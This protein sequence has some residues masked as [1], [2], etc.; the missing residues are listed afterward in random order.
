MRVVRTI[1]I[2]AAAMLLPSLLPAQRVGGDPVEVDSSAVDSVSYESGSLDDD[3]VVVRASRLRSIEVAG[4]R[5][6][7]VIGRELIE[8]S[9]RTD[10]ADALLLSPGVF[11]RRYG[12]SGS[13]ATLSLRG[14]AAGQTKIL[15]DGLPWRTSA[16]GGADLGTMPLENVEEIEVVRGGDGALYGSNALG[17]VVNIR[18]GA[19]ATPR[20]RSTIGLGSFGQRSLTLSAVHPL[21][22]VHSVHLHAAYRTATNDYPFAFHE[23]GETR[24]VRREN[25]QHESFTAGL[26]WRYD[27]DPVSA[28]I[29][30]DGFTTSRGVPGGVTQGNRELT[31]AELSEREGSAT[32]RVEG[33]IEGILLSTAVRLRLNHLRY[34]DPEAR[35]A[36]P[37]GVDNEYERSDL[38]GQVRGVWVP[39][40]RMAIEGVIDLDR[41]RLLGENLDPSVGGE[42]ERTRLGGMLH[43][44]RYLDSLPFVHRLTI[45]GGVRFDRFS[46]LGGYLSPSIGLVVQ[47]T[48]H[49][50]RLRGHVALNYRAPTFNEQYYLNVGNSEIGIERATSL[51]IGT[52]WAPTESL[53]LEGS[54]F[55]IDTRDRIVSIPRSPVSWTTLNVGRVESRGLE[56]GLR[57]SVLD[58]ALGGSLAYTRMAT[59]DR[60][61]GVT[62][63]HR[64]PYAPDEIATV[65]LVADLD[66]VRLTTS[67]E[68]ASHRYTLAWNSPETALPRYGVVDLGLGREIV[69]GDIDL[70]GSLSVRN[71]LN[72]RYQI[73]R[74]YPMPGRSLHLTLTL[75]TT[76]P[77]PE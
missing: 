7:T 45:D 61:G 67:L 55:R 12:G 76:R 77:T 71:L 63:G 37:E 31:E 53:L 22:P 43:A 10:L 3:V 2:T 69:I 49:P 48:H 46:D 20:Y 21:H 44:T 73:I 11:I 41:S 18:T 28:G 51:T 57:G 56:I 59:I 38:L 36:G 70:L 34:T 26:G 65:A 14:T 24:E 58:G 4:A 13:L 27:R 17:G 6:T 54:L 33:E 50:L 64:V 47:P 30:L 23:F 16:D 66:L 15:V 72:E 32:A 8:Q 9:G 39:D 60:A 62:D 29:S 25:S 68:Y 75:H 1:A 74:S 19:Q 40:E 5:A 52:T 42:V 35:F